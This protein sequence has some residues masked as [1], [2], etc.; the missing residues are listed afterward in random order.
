LLAAALG[1]DH[2]AV[3]VTEE[4]LNQCAASVHA[5]FAITIEYLG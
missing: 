4:R 3:V 2:P 1:G 5:H